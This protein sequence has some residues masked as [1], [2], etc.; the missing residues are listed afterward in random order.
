MAMA[1]VFFGLSVLLISVVGWL[2]PSRELPKAAPATSA[3]TGVTQTEFNVKELCQR[4]KTMQETELLRFGQVVKY[5]CLLE[6]N[7]EPPR[8][9]FIVPLGEVR[10]EWQRRHPQPPLNDSI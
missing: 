10:A 5:M 6:A 7:S 3:M 8:E 1:G 9:R 4:I 2:W